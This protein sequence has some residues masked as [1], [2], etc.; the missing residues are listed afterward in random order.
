MIARRLT[1]VI[2]L[3]VV[4]IILGWQ[5]QPSPSDNT[6]NSQA[7]SYSSATASS[8]SPDREAIA[9]D[10]LSPLSTPWE[11]SKLCAF[12]GAKV[13]TL[14]AEGHYERALA[15][16]KSYY[17]VVDLAKTKSAINV[18][19][20][21][22]ARARG[23]ALAI[24]FEQSQIPNIRGGQKLNRSPRQAD[25]LRTIAVD[26]SCY[27]PAIQELRDKTDDIEAM[28][29][30]GNLLLLADRPQEAQQ[31]FE[32]ALQL[33]A[34]GTAGKPVKAR[35][36]LEGIARAIRVEDGSSRRADALVLSLSRPI[37]VRFNIPDSSIMAR[38]HVAAARVV[39]SGIFDHDLT[40]VSCESPEDPAVKACGD[41]RLANWLNRWRQTKFNTR[42]P[43]DRQDQ[44]QQLLEDTPLSCL[45][46]I[47]IGRAISM[48]S[49]DDWT[50]AAFY[51]SA[52]KQGDK[53]LRAFPPGAPQARPILVALN[54][55]KP[56]LW[57]IVDDG[58]RN[59]VNALYILNSDLIHWVSDDDSSLRDAKAH[60]FVGAAE[61]LWV[62]GKNDEA[63]SAAQSI[64][65]SSMNDEEKRA[66]AWI[67]GLTLYSAEQFSAAADQ[68]RIVASYPDSKYTENASSL[69]AV[70][71]ARSQNIREAN[72][73]FDD[74]VRRYHP[75]VQNAAQVLD[76]MGM[77]MA[78]D[79]SKKN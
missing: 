51:A 16:A 4:L 13:K 9:I 30:C 68:F 79:E 23:K 57:A 38:V 42:I 45:T 73:A 72:T 76:R 29:G 34:R 63:L 24:E 58:D 65:T 61:C 71:L 31:Y 46:L 66:V 47:S 77:G 69:L 52:A 18:M 5:L 15:A 20:T 33:A 62:M 43:K 75:K 26:S 74:W 7:N 49:I 59:F 27:E 70:S 53:E 28:I 35:H 50:A 60:G 21:A 3:L 2:I 37:P 48:Q 39:T 6:V 78:Q 41:A 40:L 8:R 64:D 25:I 14:T 1:A 36:A 32:F 10:Y 44:V 54:S 56:T 12:Q 67:R 11:L 55:A 17:N 22:L 19:T